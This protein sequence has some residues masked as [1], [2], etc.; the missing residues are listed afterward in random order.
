LSLLGIDIGTSGCRAVAFGTDGVVRAAAFR[1]YAIA[2]SA[3]GHAEHDADAVWNAVQACMREVNETVGAADPV[4]AL[5]VASQG[6]AV[7]PLDEAGRALAPAPISVDYRAAE[8]AS[9]IADRVGA[10]RLRVVSGAP[11]HPMFTVFKLLWWLRHDPEG[12]GRAHRFLC[13]GDFAALRLGVEPAIDYTLAART[14]AL[15]VHRR[16]WSDEI[17]AAAGLAPARLARPVPSGTP[18][19]R[20][21]RALSGALGFAAPPLVVAGAHDQAAA[22]WGAGVH[23]LGQA[24]FSLGTSDCLAAPVAAAAT[25]LERSVYPYYPYDDA[26]L[27]IVLAGIP[28]GGAM[29]GW[30]LDEV[31]GADKTEEGD[32]RS[33]FDILYDT[34]AD[35]AGGALVLPHFA[36]SGT[37][38]DDA[39]SSG[40]IVGL[41]LATTRGQIARALVEASGFEAGRNL[42]EWAA[43]GVSVEELRVS[44]GG[45]RSTRALSAR[46]EALSRPLVV[47]PH[48]GEATARGAALLAGVGAGFYPSIA[49]AAATVDGEREI[50]PDPTRA[51]ALEGA[52]GR[53]ALLYAALRAVREP[54]WPSLSS[55]GVLVHGNRS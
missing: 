4:E 28:S 46:A 10:G 32:G 36:G 14:A 55:E 52:R 47:P 31:V 34:M 35:D 49:D 11:A 30:F 41:T 9:E 25:Q 2:R 17:L 51:A 18:L 3:P 16:A 53:Y 6:E 40:A 1:A 21:E 23:R 38:D 7:V 42:A 15:D 8:E 26:D 27:S 13:Y 33:R 45:A 22:M 12:A 37:L 44:G 54:P 5:A 24:G 19:G 48:P 50:A 20:V 43:L 29:I 39:A